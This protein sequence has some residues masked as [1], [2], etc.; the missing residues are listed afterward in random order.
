[1]EKYIT[2]IEISDTQVRLAVGYVENGK[3]NLIHVAERPVTGLISRGEIIDFQT[4]SSILYSM[5]E[6]KDETTKEKIT[7]SEA[8]V[9]LPS[10]GLN[11]FQSSKTTN[12]V[13]PYSL[14]ATIDIENVVSLVQKE[15]IPSGSAI[16][17]IIPD[18]FVLE[19]GRSFVNPPINEKSNNITIKAKIQTLPTRVVADYKRIFDTARIKIRRMCVSSYALA[20][21]ARNDSDMPESYILADIGAGVTNISLIGNYSPFDTVSFQFGMEDLILKISQRFNISREEAYDLVQKYG[22]D[23]RPLTYKPTILTSLIDGVETN[24]DPDT[25]NFII[26]EFFKEE[27]FDK[28]DAA[29]S[30]IMKGY[31]DNVRNLPIVFTGGIT[32]MIGFE[33]LV[34][35]KFSSNASIHYLEP[36]C[37]GARDTR[38]SA[39][40][41]GIYAS[42][43]YKGAL[44]D[45]RLKTTEL[46]R[47]REKS[48]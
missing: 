44:S 6:F 2:T 3:V 18:S 19:M 20:E 22:L 36:K 4:L 41:G 31:A 17:D 35:E 38:F 16:I 29:F 27:Y 8:T 21:L 13:S 32:K 42:S 30:T 43:K 24:H 7:I 34:K 25:L 33:G 37:M 28:F 46:Q 47:V 11:V 23:E 12:V 26:N 9:I 40:V 5:R 48:E 1:M 10:F 39:L 45:T 15:A 14:I